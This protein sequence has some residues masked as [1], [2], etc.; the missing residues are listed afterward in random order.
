MVGREFIEPAK[1]T[2]D[3]PPAGVEL[4]SLSPPPGLRQHTEIPGII[5]FSNQVGIVKVAADTSS[6][7]AVATA[8]RTATRVGAALADEQDPER[9]EK[10]L[11]IVD[12]VSGREFRLAGVGP[13]EL[14][15]PT[16]EPKSYL[17]YAGT[18]GGK[19]TE[20]GAFTNPAFVGAAQAD[21]YAHISDA[22]R[23][24]QIVAKDAKGVAD[25]VQKKDLAGA[26]DLYDHTVGTF[27][28][29]HSNDPGLVTN[30]LHGFNTQLNQVMP[31][32]KKEMENQ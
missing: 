22:D 26:V 29:R 9:G 30:Y 27:L 12:T 1:N 32:L 8:Q 4:T 11:A 13:Y 19:L 5:P 28:R 14:T 20:A 18:L 17:A 31:D 15:N 23:L 21:Y 3:D 25:L 16:T 24:D 10:A 2:P 6:E 7:A